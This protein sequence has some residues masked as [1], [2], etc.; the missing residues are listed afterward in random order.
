MAEMRGRPFNDPEAIREWA[1]DATEGIKNPFVKQQMR[2][3]ANML[4]REGRWRGN[5]SEYWKH[6]FDIDEL[7]R[8]GQLK[9]LYL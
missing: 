1:A 5:I 2:Q 4:I 3:T 8:S 7:I 6:H 9:Y